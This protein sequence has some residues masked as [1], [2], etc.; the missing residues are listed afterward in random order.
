[1]YS[2]KNLLNLWYIWKLIIQDAE[3]KSCIT[4]YKLSIPSFSFKLTSLWVEDFI[5]DTAVDVAI[6]SNYM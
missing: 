6:G 4:F 3:N 1:M 2:P 5:S